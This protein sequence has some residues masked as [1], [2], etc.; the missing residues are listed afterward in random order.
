MEKSQRERD[1]AQA[2]Y[3]QECVEFQMTMEAIHECQALLRGLQDG[4]SS[5]VEVTKAQKNI[6]KII[7]ESNNR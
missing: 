2:V 5:F 6:K 4:R 1:E 7:F 3:E